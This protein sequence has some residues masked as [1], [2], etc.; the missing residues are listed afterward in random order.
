MQTLRLSL[1][2]LRRDL[3]AGELNLLVVALLIA[4][5]AL[6]SVG[7]FTDRVSQALKRDAN[8]LLGG[9]LLVSADH[10]LPVSFRDE[11]RR[12]GVQVTETVLFN[13]MASTDDLAQLAAVKAVE[14]GYPLRG[15]VRISPRMGDL[16]TEAG[17]IPARGEAWLEERLITALQ[18]EPGDNIQ[19]GNLHFRVGALVTFESDRGTGFFSFVPRIMINAADLPA[20]GLIQ[21][22]SRVRYRLQFAGDAA[23]VARLNAWL[24]PR[25]GRGETMEGL[26]NARP[27]VRNGLDRADRFLRLAAMLTVVLA[28]VAI[29]LSARRYLQRHVDGCAVMR[30]FGARRRQLMSLYFAEFLL[31]SIVV[32]LIGCFAGFALQ[33]VLARLARSF[34][35]ADLPAPGW[36]TVGQGVSVS[37]VLMLGFVMPL[38]LRLTR[39][40]PVHVLRREWGGIEAGSSSV[41]LAGAAALS[42]LMLW[43]ANDLKLGFSVLGGF[44]VAVVVFVLV[45]WLV[46]GAFGRAR[47]LHGNWGLRYGLA[48][49]YRRRASSV[50]Q[51]VALALGLTAVLLL[52]LVSHDLL[53]AWRKRQ[54]PDAPN[55][56]VLNIQPEQRAAVHDFFVAH[57]LAAP[58]LL[59]M[60]RGRL[61]S[62]N[63]RAVKAADYKDER[64]RGLVER[65]FNLSWASVLQAGNQIVAGRWHGDA[66]AP[67][68]SM[69][70]G[71]GER[72]G[73]HLGDEVSFEIAGQR[74]SG[75][76]SSIRKLDWDSMR[77]NFFFTA[78]PGLLD[79][80]PASYITSFYLPEGRGAVINE[81]V[82]AFPNLTVIDVGEVLSQVIE[83]TD[84]LVRMVNFVLAFALVAGVVVLLA[85][86]QSTHDERMFELSVLRTLGARHRQ[87][88]RAMLAEFAVL[89]S[90]AALLAIAGAVGIGMALAHFVFELPYAP[91]WPALLGAGAVTAVIVVIAGWLGVRGLLRQT[92]LEGLR[93]S[94]T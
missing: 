5:A 36:V 28:A 84:R 86:L 15:S 38:L 23:A 14:S 78:A 42:G 26:D 19:L 81:L 30:C 17:R 29:G 16:G 37:V 35:D 83:M 27:E 11:A 58:E 33:D 66:R 69:E 25:L 40:P 76:I 39:V 64:A 3:R 24:K 31:L 75:K 10:P 22:G 45:A 73:L 54:P 65:E 52:T 82:N 68:F 62:I 9:D 44:A 92:V 4:V 7:F 50:I 91:A 72:L 41:W 85:S 49:L 53:D 8:Q 47:V 57:A 94:A 51:A 2:M 48:A 67:E 6:S 21:E 77:V 20:T 70:Q 87:L 93:A 18:V 34:V 80:Y 61:V 59:P 71:I 55:Q 13:S 32:G 90:V 89:G 1:T 63:G 56:F 60:V 46:L 88:R 74:V 12:L 43:V 79:N